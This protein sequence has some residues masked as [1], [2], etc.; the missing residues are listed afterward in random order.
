MES[1]K[2]VLFDIS[3]QRGGE[4]RAIGRRYPNFIEQ[5]LNKEHIAMNDKR[6]VKRTTEQVSYNEIE[7]R[8]SLLLLATVRYIYIGKIVS[9]ASDNR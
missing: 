8:V 3:K 5:V 6:T 9:R 1:R 7:H 4:R 2:G